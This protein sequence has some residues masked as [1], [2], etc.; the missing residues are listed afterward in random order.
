MKN[1]RRD[2]WTGSRHKG[3]VRLLTAVK[4]ATGSD[5]NTG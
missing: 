1:I 5:F 2:P 4:Y 3:D